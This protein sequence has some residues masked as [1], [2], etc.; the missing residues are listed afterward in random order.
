MSFTFQNISV[1]VVNHTEGNLT[2][3]GSAEEVAETIYELSEMSINDQNKWLRR[4]GADI[5]ADG[6]SNYDAEIKADDLL[7]DLLREIDLELDDDE[8]KEEAIAK[9]TQAL[10][11]WV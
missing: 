2:I 6:S 10:N 5:E 3:G 7:D 4:G 11:D 9:I 8:T 1:E